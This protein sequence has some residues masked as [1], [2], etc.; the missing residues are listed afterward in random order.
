M[1]V[2]VGGTGG[3]AAGAGATA[4]S[5]AAT[6]GAAGV[7]ATSTWTS[8]AMGVGSSAPAVHMSHHWNVGIEAL[9][10]LWSWSWWH[11][12]SHPS[13]NATRNDTGLDQSIQLSPP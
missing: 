10:I 11:R 12:H 3:G 13:S 1:S 4:G 9:K 2:V 6:G 8:S 7:S 5:G